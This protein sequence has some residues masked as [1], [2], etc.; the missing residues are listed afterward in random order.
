MTIPSNQFSEIETTAN[1]M[2][3]VKTPG[4]PKG[5][6][7]QAAQ[8]QRAKIY[9]LYLRG[10]SE[11]EIAESLTIHQSTVSRSLSIMRKKNVRWFLDNKYP[12]DRFQ[13]LFKATLD[14][15]W[16]TIRE[17]WILYH[18]T[19]DGKVE[20][21]VNTIGRIQSGIALYCK[22]LGIVAPSLDELYWHDQIQKINKDLDEWKT[23]GS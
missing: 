2:Q 10:F 23:S 15:I 20:A 19:P 7:R 13:N 18:N 9:A 6:T 12:I 4:R 14:A 22:I 1:L 8:K 3:Q 16:E 17:S 21:R 11:S 5:M